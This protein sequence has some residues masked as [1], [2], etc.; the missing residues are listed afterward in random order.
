MTVSE[1]TLKN[2]VELLKRTSAGLNILR[3]E[4]LGVLGK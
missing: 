1:E 4:E 2:E 3:K